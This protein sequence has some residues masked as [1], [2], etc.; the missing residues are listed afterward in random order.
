MLGGAAFFDRLFPRRVAVRGQMC[1]V[2]GLGAGERPIRPGHSGAYGKR[3]SELFN[4]NVEGDNMGRV[5]R[6]AWRQKIEGD[7]R[8]R[9]DANPYSGS[10]SHTDDCSVSP[11]EICGVGRIRA[12]GIIQADGEHY[13]LGAL[14]RE[15]LGK[16]SLD[17][18]QPSARDARVK[19]RSAANVGKIGELGNAVA[20]DDR[21]KPGEFCLRKNG[22]RPSYSMFSGPVFP[23]VRPCRKETSRDK[24]H[25]YCGV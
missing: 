8:D 23:I 25:A 21:I 24:G 13:P 6:R 17:V 14:R 3:L 19:H 22:L 7:R 15:N 5:E 1:A 10:L 11:S 2:R 9:R 20:E 16:Q 12:V 4:L 18:R